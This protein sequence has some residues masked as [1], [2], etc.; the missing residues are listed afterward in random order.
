[1]MDGGEM[2]TMIGIDLSLVDQEVGLI[3]GTVLAVVD[4]GVVVVTLAVMMAVEVGVVVVATVGDGLIILTVAEADGQV[5]VVVPPGEVVAAA[6]DL[7]AEMLEGV[8]TATVTM[9]AEAG[10]QLLVD[11]MV[12]MVPVEAG[13]R[14]QLLVALILDSALTTQDGAAPK[15]WSQHRMVEVGLPAVVGA[16]EW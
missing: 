13:E 15:S 7:E 14:E 12:V 5:A 9:V 8:A 11:L 1:M 16:G 3:Q 10:E 4:A 6:E 2:V